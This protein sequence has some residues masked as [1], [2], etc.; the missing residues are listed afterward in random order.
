[1]DKLIEIDNKNQTQFYFIFNNSHFREFI[2]YVEDQ[3]SDDFLNFLVL[4]KQFDGFKNGTNHTLIDTHLIT[5]IISKDKCD[6]LKTVVNYASEYFTA[7]QG[8]YP[9]YDKEEVKQRII[10]LTLKLKDYLTYFMEN[11]TDLLKYIRYQNYVK[12]GND[13]IKFEEFE[14]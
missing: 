14:Q 9:D 4:K 1:M 5:S 12:Q 2:K 6:K 10:C 3:T 8:I 7:N 13:Y 11:H